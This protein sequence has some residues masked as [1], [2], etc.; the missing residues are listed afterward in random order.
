[1]KVNYT[2]SKCF[3]HCYNKIVLLEFT[4][5]KIVQIFTISFIKVQLRSLALLTIR[6]AMV[7]KFLN[8][9]MNDTF[10]IQSVRPHGYNLYWQVLAFQLMPFHHYFKLPTQLCIHHRILQKGM[11]KVICIMFHFISKEQCYVMPSL[12]E[13]IQFNIGSKTIINKFFRPNF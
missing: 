11:F 4:I 2:W 1:M 3:L 13:R 7:L 9:R 5:R 12:L 8:R 10:E 6:N